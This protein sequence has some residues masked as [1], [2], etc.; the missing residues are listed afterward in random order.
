[1]FAWIS[2]CVAVVLIAGLAGLTGGAHVATGMAE[3]LLGGCLL[4]AVVMV[5]G[6]IL[7]RRSPF[8][9]ANPHAKNKA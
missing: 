5:V 3:I 8:N 4:L 1:M 2:V 9:G 6:A 7:R